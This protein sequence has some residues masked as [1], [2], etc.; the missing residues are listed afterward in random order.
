MIQTLVPQR[1]NA[2]TILRWYG[3]LQKALVVQLKHAQIFLGTNGDGLCP[4]IM[5]LEEIMKV[6]SPIQCL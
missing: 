2:G 5:V 6:N 4:A 1:K 3:K